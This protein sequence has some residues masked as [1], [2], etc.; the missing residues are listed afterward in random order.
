MARM[1]TPLL[2][3][4]QSRKSDQRSAVSIQLRDA[5]AKDLRMAPPPKAM[6][7]FRSEKL[8]KADC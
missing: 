1:L 7:S 5:T 4:D 6:A 2:T 3:N 8:L